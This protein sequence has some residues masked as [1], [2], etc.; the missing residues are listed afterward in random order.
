MAGKTTTIPA[1]AL[2]SMA[3]NAVAGRDALLG[4]EMD[5]CVDYDSAFGPLVDRLDDGAWAAA[6]VLCGEVA[7][8]AYEMGRE[9]GALGAT[10]RIE[11]G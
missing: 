7:R 6:G 2:D 11:K 1:E 9:D 10:S 3:E 8:R 5:A 4:N